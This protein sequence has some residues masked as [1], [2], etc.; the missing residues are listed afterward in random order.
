MFRDAKF[1]LVKL[2]LM[3]FAGL[4]STAHA[5][6]FMGMVGVGKDDGGERIYSGSY[7]TGVSWDVQTNT[8]FLFRIGG[9]VNMGILQTQFAAGYKKN[10]A[11]A[12]NGYAYFDTY[13]L[14]LFEY[15]RIGSLRLGAGAIYHVNTKLKISG[16][17]YTGPDT[18][19]FDNAMGSAAEIGWI[20]SD[21]KDF[22]AS[23]DLRATKAR[24]KQ[25]DVANAYEYNGDVVGLNI[26][27][28]FK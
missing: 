11:N 24:F 20:I 13:P 18:Y 23:L 4:A 5:V 1:R 21:E 7:T 22:M 17:G 12:T 10:G 25:K 27:V 16:P 26:S 6:D 2:L 8:G 15:I 14:E 19:E 3:M 9:A 28:Y